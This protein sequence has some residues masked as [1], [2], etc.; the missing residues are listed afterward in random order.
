MCLWHNALLRRLYDLAY[1]MQTC[2]D[3][4]E[5]T[6]MRPT[7][8][9]NFSLAIYDLFEGVCHWRLWYMLG[10][11]EIK[12]RYRRS[13]LGPFWLT[14]SVGVQVLVMGFIF[15]FLFEHKIERFIPFLCISL[16]LWTFLSTTIMDGSNSLVNASSLITQVK[17]PLS[18][19]ILQAVWRNIIILCHTIVIFVVVSLAFGM[20]PGA[21]WLLAPF[22]FFIFLANIAWISLFVAILSARF[23]DV[24]LIVQNAFTIL[25]WLTPVFYK[26]EQL[27]EGTMADLVLL[28]PLFH[29]LEVV[30]APLILQ[31]PSTAN[32]LIAGACAVFGWAITILLFS[33]ARARI[34][35]WV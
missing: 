26:P 15:G 22:G 27:G 3:N 13:S 18:V 31:Y 17:R 11:N 10:L 9:E 29:I 32:W 5:R 2:L 8:R 34:A 20:F 4:S 21:T 25:F 6:L 28:N 23:R 14:L 1:P 24:P 33:R 19:H 35:Y 30:R 12:H 7:N 16:V